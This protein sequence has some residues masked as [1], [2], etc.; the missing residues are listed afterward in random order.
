M[1][2]MTLTSEVSPFK[3]VLG[4]LDP[5]VSLQSWLMFLLTYVQ[6]QVWPW[7]GCVPF[8]FSILHTTGFTTTWF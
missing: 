5:T 4:H 6:G 3:L 1:H 8:T 2:L 7:E